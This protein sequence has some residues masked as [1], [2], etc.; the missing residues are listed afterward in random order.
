[1]RIA[2]T[3]GPIE[4][5]E[6]KY[7]N[8]ARMAA[9]YLV[10]H[11]V[12]HDLILVVPAP[13]SAQE[14]TFLSAVMLREFMQHLGIELDAIDLFSS[15]T[16]ARRSRLLYQMALGKKVRVGVLADE[17]WSRVN[18]FSVDWA[19]LGKVFLLVGSTRFSARTLGIIINLYVREFL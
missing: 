19:Y 18:R 15:G 8:Y 2:T 13:P 11:G 10:K 3:G 16:H 12:P 17:Q 14:R 4:W 6:T 5:P 1:M 7:G 9:D